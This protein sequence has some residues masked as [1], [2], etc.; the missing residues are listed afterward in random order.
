MKKIYTLLITLILISCN[1]E[2]TTYYKN[3]DSGEILTELEYSNLGNEIAE[4]YGNDSLDLK[5]EFSLKKNYSSKDSLIQPFGIDVRIGENYIIS[6]S[7][8]DKIYELIGESLPD[9]ELKTINGTF[10]SKTDILQKPC[11]INFW[12]T[13]CPPCIEEI[14]D[15]N[16][17]KEQ[18]SDKVNFIA[19]TFDNKMELSDFLKKTKFDFIHIIDAQNY[20]DNIGVR[21][22]PKNVFIDKNGKI[23]L[24]E[25]GLSNNY[26]QFEKYLND[27]L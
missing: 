15:L 7:N 19:I 17:L 21:A 9:F 27:L 16:R 25:N 24:I 5:I 12:F 14:P 10:I 11:L 2:K 18:Y 13:Q 3:I 20:I 1:Q 6:S 4:K 22:F 8:R 23:K 26:E